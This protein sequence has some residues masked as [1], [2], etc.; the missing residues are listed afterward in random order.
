MASFV[1]DDS[2]QQ[3][4]SVTSGFG[5]TSKTK[6]SLLLSSSAGLYYP[7]AN[8]IKLY[9]SS[10]DALT[11]DSNGIISGNGSGLTNFASVQIPSLNAAKITSGTFGTSF[12][13]SLDVSKITSGIFG[14]SFIPSLDVSKITTGTFGTSFIPSLDASKVTTGT[15]TASQIPSLDASKITTGILNTSLYPS[16]SNYVLTTTL[17]SQ[18]IINSNYFINSNTSTNIFNNL[19]GGYDTIA[20]RN[21]A[22]SSYLLTATASSTYATI[23]NLGLKENALTFSAPLTRTTNTIGID[24]SL[25]D[26]IALRNTAIANQNVINSNYFISSN[27]STNIFNN[28]IGGYDTIALRNTAIANQNT[29]NS[30]YFITSNTSTN[31]FNNLIGGYDTIALRN[32]AIANQNVINSNYFISSN[33]STNIFNN[34]I[35]GYDTISARNTALG[36][37]LLLSGGTMTGTLIQNASTP[38]IQMGNTN[39]NNFGL[40]SSAGVFSTSASTGDMVIRSINNLI[41]QSGA[42]AGAIV[43]NSTNNTT[44]NG[45]LTV[46]NNLGIQHSGPNLSLATIDSNNYGNTSY[47]NSFAGDSHLYSYWGLSVNLNSAGANP[48]PNSPYTRI[49]YTSSFTV[50]QKSV[51]GT[52]TSGFT[53]LFTILQ[54]GNVGVGITNPSSIFQIGN[55]GRLKISSGSTDYTLIGTNDTDGTTNTK[56]VLSGTSRGS[57]YNGNIEYRATS[58][59]HEF[60]TNGTTDVMRIINNGNVGISS[61]SPSEK[62][63]VGGNIKASGTITNGSGSYM[64]AGGLRL[65]GFDT[66]NTIYNGNANMGLT[67]NNGYSVNFGVNGYGN[68]MTINNSSVLINSATP[69]YIGLYWSI[70]YASIN[71]VINSLVFRHYD[72][73]NGINSFWYFNGTQANTM[74]EISDERIKKN[75]QSINTSNALDLINQL[76]PKSFNLLDDKD[77]NFKYGFIAQ[78]VEQIPSLSNLVFT[79]TDYI[80]NIN[81]LATHSNI[82][83]NITLITSSN[84]IRD[85]IDVNDEI[86]LVFDNA[87]NQEFVID[88]T[89]YKNRYKRRYANVVEIVDDNSFIIDNPINIDITDPFL[90]YGK[91]VD[92]FKQVDYQSLFSLSISSIQELYKIIQSQQKQIDYL[93][94]NLVIN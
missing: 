77:A 53:N 94:S 47:Y 80:A 46:N 36:S 69:L 27:I 79:T 62:L 4:N 35:G 44:I 48:N 89:P 74:S 91:K 31:I 49:P 76:Q 25:Y 13:P 71:A 65:G 64:Y 34:L 12:I 19:I 84:S 45:I 3:S 61:G 18:N 26:T 87:S 11:I 30:N 92:D 90:L 17:N 41:F 7:S 21:T 43:V 28:L 67:V 55:A 14:T 40:A 73:G 82:N 59:K 83:G 72:T 57:P 70:F 1:T 86:K 33:I 81:S 24:L 66:G 16:L 38:N 10:N 20:L 15:F 23:T 37:Y 39:G 22:L 50:N 56:I 29:I 5:F 75:I 51:G 88:D 42:G 2:T 32:T 78:E 60:Y 6:P 9:T 68:S 52:A 8:T 63:D 85:L 93:T 58:G 54:N